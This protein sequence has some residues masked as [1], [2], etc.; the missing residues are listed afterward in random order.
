MGFIKYILFSLIILYCTIASSNELA[1]PLVVSKGHNKT[2]TEKQAVSDQSFDARSSDQR[3]ANGSETKPHSHGK[4]IAAGP[5]RILAWY[6]LTPRIPFDR[7]KTSFES[8]IEA[9]R[10]LKR[11]VEKVNNYKDVRVIRISAVEEKPKTDGLT[12]MRL[13]K[14]R[15]SL[16]R[17][18]AE[19]AIIETKNLG[20][21]MVHSHNRDGLTHQEYQRRFESSVSIS[22]KRQA[23][24]DVELWAWNSAHDIPFEKGK[25]TSIYSDLS[26]P[27]VPYHVE[28]EMY[29]FGGFLIREI[30][31]S[32]EVD[33]TIRKCRLKLIRKKLIEAGASPDSIL[34]EDD[35]IPYR[36]TLRDKPTR[37][38]LGTVE[39]FVLHGY[40]DNLVSL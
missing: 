7:G 10:L 27:Y 35:S 32:T 18:G 33:P 15:K 17:L 1:A 37:P 5:N 39:I 36:N 19:P 14:T 34:G 38:I 16:V 21:L 8:P 23:S 22:L 12:E 13:D 20:Y 28:N 29:V 3:V 25:C 26:L 31:E 2:F 9:E 11:I 4:H 40:F 24:V 30:P 6:H